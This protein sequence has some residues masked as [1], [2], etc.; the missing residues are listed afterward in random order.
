MDNVLIHF[1]PHVYLKMGTHGLGSAIL[2]DL[3]CGAGTS[4]NVQNGGG[5]GWLGRP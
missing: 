5:P 1:H 3:L 4:L 2:I